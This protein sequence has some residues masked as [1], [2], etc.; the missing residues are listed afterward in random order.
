MQRFENIQVED[1]LEMPASRGS[2]IYGAGKDFDPDRTVRVVIVTNIWFDPVEKKELIGIADL[3]N[4]GT[5]GD[6]KEKR[7]LR[8]LAMCGWRPAGRDWIAHLKAVQAN[9]DND[10]VVS[11]F[12]RRAK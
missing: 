1:Q 6:P 4:D 9:K 10:A 8:G 7:T 5:Y 3:R 2:I 11:I 12:G